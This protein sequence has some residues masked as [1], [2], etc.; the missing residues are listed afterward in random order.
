MADVYPFTT[1]VTELMTVMITVTRFSVVHLIR[2]VHLQHLHVATGEESVFP[3]TGAVTTTMTV[4]MA[5]MSRTVPP[6]RKLPVVQTTSPV[7]ITCVSQRTGCATQ[8][9]T[10]GM[11]LMKRDAILERPAHLLNFIALI[12]DVLT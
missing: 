12:I 6:K 5:V 1:A 8:I 2:P 7:I 10:V 4:W 11:D 9:M 3:H